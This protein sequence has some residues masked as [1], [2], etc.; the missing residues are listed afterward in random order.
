MDGNGISLAA[1]FLGGMASFVSPCILPIVPVYL[2]LIS[3]LSFDE[4]QEASSVRQARW[5]LFASALAF[6]LGFSVVTVLL[7]GTLASMVNELG[8]GWKMAIRWFGGAV[9]L[10]FALHLFGVFRINALFKERRFHITSNKFGVLGAAVIGAAFAFGWT[11]CIGTIL[12][13]V[14]TFAST[15]SPAM[16]W[17]LFVTYT[18][19]LAVPFILAAIFVNLFLGSLRKMTRHLRTVE[20]ITGVLLLAMGVLLVT[21]QLTIISEHGRFLEPLN[22]RLEDLFK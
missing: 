13:T 4:L 15:A 9:V 5:R 3:G 1:V 6:V 10:V 18:I 22:A 8:D 2:S 14:F 11:P 20:I 19:G 21:N 16:V 17:W 7:L 12:F